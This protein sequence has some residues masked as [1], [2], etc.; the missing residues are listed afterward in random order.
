MQGQCLRDSECHSK[1]SPKL[2]NVSPAFCNAQWLI[3]LLFPT[4]IKQLPDT[5][6][7]LLQGALTFAAM[8][9][10]SVLLTLSRSLDHR[11][12]AHLWLRRQMTLKVHVQGTSN[13]STVQ[14][15]IDTERTV[16]CECPD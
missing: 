12:S 5:R 7:S 13:A 15:V 4:P 11:R 3:T 6:H 9:L 2:Q 16:F 14:P 1:P 10:V 8:F